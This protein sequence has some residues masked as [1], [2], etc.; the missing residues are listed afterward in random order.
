V[1]D[2]TDPVDGLIESRRDGIASRI[3]TIDSRINDLEKRMEK[4][5]ERLTAKY[6]AL[7]K[8]VSSFQAQGSALQGFGR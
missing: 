4:F 5:E 2:L 6:A 7:E 3:K 8:L 1:D